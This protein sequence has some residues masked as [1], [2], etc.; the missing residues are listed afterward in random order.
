MTRCPQTTAGGT[1]AR[2][3]VSVALGTHNGAAFLEPQLR[4]ILTQSH[5]VQEV[6]LSDDASSD[7]SVALAEGLIEEHRAADA[8]TP[9]LVV[10]RNPTALGV[11]ANFE[12][13]LRA[14][15]GDLVVL[16]DQDDVWRPDRIARAL[17]EFTARPEVELVASDARLVDGSGAALGSTLFD[18]LGVDAALLGRFRSDGS[19]DELLR[20]NVVTGATMAI[21]RRLVERAVPFPESWVHD[22]WLAMVAS[23]GGGLSLIDEPL[24]DYR[25]HGGNQIECAGSRRREAREAARA[26]HGPERAVARA[27]HRS[28]RA[29]LRHRRGRS[30]GRGGGRGEACARAGAHR[31]P[32]RASAAHPPIVE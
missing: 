24:I 1:T 3:T 4:S 12:Q 26:A 11:T 21:A 7:G 29:T 18:T 16:A 9:S 10:L 23:V 14:A 2:P 27:R 5:P 19:F 28:R 31:S 30:R 6:V 22:E 15:S 20:R 25:Q 13:A 17:R 8:P 32:R